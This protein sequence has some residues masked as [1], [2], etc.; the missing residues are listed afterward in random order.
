MRGT[1][2]LN[3]Q[4]VERSLTSAI[5]RMT[6]ECLG[7]ASELRKHPQGAWFGLVWPAPFGCGPQEAFPHVSQAL[8]SRS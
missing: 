6:D 3:R 5:Q 1:T 4:P 7:H 8:A 2:L